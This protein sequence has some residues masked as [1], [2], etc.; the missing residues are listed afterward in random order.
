MKIKKGIQSY[1][2]S[3]VKLEKDV[4]PEED[5]VSKTI[6]NFGSYQAI[7][8]PIAGI[9]RLIV[10]WNV[11]CIVFLTPT[12]NFTCVK[13]KDNQIRNVTNSTCYADCIE[14][15][16]HSP[17]LEETLISSFGLIC[18]NAW[19]ASFT[20]TIAMLGLVIGVSVFGWI[21]DRFGRRIAYILSGMTT[22][23]FTLA[24]SF[25]PSY[26]AFT[27]MRFFAGFGSGGVM[28]LS[29]VL[30]VEM[31]GPKYREISGAMSLLADG[32]AVMLLAAIGA[33][34]SSWRSMLLI[35]GI[36][37]V[38]ILVMLMFLPETP[39][40]LI[41][42]RKTEEAVALM[43]KIAKFNGLNTSHIRETVEEAVKHLENQQM[44]V[45]KYTFL[46][47]F[48]NMK[49]ARITVTSVAMWIAG[50]ICYFG[51]NQYSTLLGLNIFVV[52]PM[53]GFFQ[54][55]GNFLALPANRYFK[56]RMSLFTAFITVGIFM[57]ILIF[58]PYAHWGCG[59]LTCTGLVFAIMIICIAYVHSSEVY[60]TPL[61]NM[62]IGVC[63]GGAKVGA[64]IAPFIANAHPHWIAETILTVIPFVG[65]LL[66]L[67][68]PE[69]KGKEIKDTVD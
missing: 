59:V 49:L 2:I 45:Q 3:K 34:I 20:Q 31:V 51:I 10:M 44:A 17:V 48:R 67:L 37:G 63:C 53:M 55:I 8:C 56:R 38:L 66:S 62:G 35:F 4:K 46:D 57:L 22:V 21:S 28:T 9:S 60:P 12:T 65:A 26:W 64:M 33:P 23:I 58:V 43:T 18:G 11:M 68:L 42:Q 50:G 24:S 36:V 30:N 69:T 6:G 61:R 52:V 7:V 19:L 15:A 5:Y 39:R 29:V 25:A 14:Y 1:V 54:I 40:W 47:L 27:A 16:Y 41:S 32:V 13:F